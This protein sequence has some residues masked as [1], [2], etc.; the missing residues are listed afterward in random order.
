MRAASRAAR[1]ALF[2]ASGS[3]MFW[4]LVRSRATIF[5]LHRFNDPEIGVDGLDGETLRRSLAAL[6]RQRFEI[7][8][9]TTLVQDLVEG[10]EHAAPAVAFTIDDGY[11]DH[12]KVAAP[13]FARPW[14]VKSKVTIG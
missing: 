6:R 1:R 2:A 7:L 3:R 8:P 14:S 12:A 11:L 13:I 10:R 5:M 4:P 9:L